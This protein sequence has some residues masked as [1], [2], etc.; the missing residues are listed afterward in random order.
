MSRFYHNRT[1][2]YVARDGELRLFTVYGAFRLVD[3]IIAA[4]SA[5]VKYAR[6]EA[7]VA[8]S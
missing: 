4:R 1:T 7:P 6:T 8:P 3:S 5:M 2:F